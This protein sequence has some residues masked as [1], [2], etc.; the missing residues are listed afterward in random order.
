MLLRDLEWLLLLAEHENV[1]DA[2]AVIGTSQPTLSRALSRLEDELDARLFERVPSG[3]VATPDGELVVEAA[4]DIVRRHTLLRD[5]LRARHDPD[6]GTVRLAF[7][8]SM[9]TSL[10][11]QVLRDF[12]AHAPGVRVVLRQESGLDIVG[13]LASRAADLAITSMRP[14]GAFGWHVVQRES[15]VVVVPAKHRLRRRKR[16]ALSDLA[17]D[18]LVTTPSG[19]GYRAA[20]EDLMREA[21]IVLPISFESTDLATIEG[22]VAAGLG[23]AIVP[24]QFAGLSG[25]VG[26]KLDSAAARRTIGLTWRTDVPLPPPAQRMLDFVRDR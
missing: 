12:H 2:S 26:I 14:E 1:T 6:A 21:G 7:V 24:E 9:A 8:S 10:V 17:G 3:V 19:F 5:E 18:E 13:D 16:I 23:V 20:V 11:P 22:L 25:T 15:L 4:R